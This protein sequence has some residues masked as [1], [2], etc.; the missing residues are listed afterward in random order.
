MSRLPEK[1]SAVNLSNEVITAVCFSAIL[2]ATP[3]S[4]AIYYFVPPAVIIVLTA[5]DSAA[6]TLFVGAVNV[7]DLVVVEFGLSSI[8]IRSQIHQQLGKLWS[9][10]DEKSVRSETVDCAHRRPLG[11]G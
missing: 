3:A 5:A 4:T 8:G 10:A 2:A 1:W 11:L 6:L 7:S 9:L